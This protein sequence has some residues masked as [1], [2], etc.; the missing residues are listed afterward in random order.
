MDPNP[1]LVDYVESGQLV[2]PWKERRAFL[3]EEENKRY[4]REYNDR[5]GYDHEESPIVNALYSVFESIGDKLSFYKGV[6]T[7]P[8]EALERFRRRIGITVDHETPP[9]YI[10]RQGKI[11]LPFDGALEMAKQFCAVEPATV[12]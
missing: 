2:V 3:K 1:G 12:D 4:L 5:H 9:T 7:S 8:L 6:L 11:Q 10:D